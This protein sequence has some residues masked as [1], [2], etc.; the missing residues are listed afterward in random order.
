VDSRG[1]GQ[2][3]DSPFGFLTAALG[4]HT[5]MARTIVAP[6]GE[7]G[8]LL[9]SR[10]PLTG[11][12][13]HDVSLKRYE[14]RCVIE[15][16]THTPQGLLH[17]AAVHLGLRFS[18]RRAQVAKLARIAGAGG[19]ASVMMGDFN[20]WVWRGSVKRVLSRE[21]PAHTHFCTFPS[22][23]PFLML[24]RIYCRPGSALVRSWTDRAARDISDHLPVLVDLKLPAP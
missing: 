10:W 2:G 4:V 8:H 5:A 7:Y 15:A 13:L 11:V 6:D 23:R 17:V 20:D 12:V 16:F 24:D 3:P 18:E 19:K 14:K 1:R 9:I 22:A 21:L